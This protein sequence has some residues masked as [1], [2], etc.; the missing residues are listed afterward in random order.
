M[1]TLLYTFSLYINTS[2]LTYLLRL[3]WIFDPPSPKNPS[4]PF[5]KTPYLNS[6]P[7]LTSIQL[8]SIPK[9]NPLNQSCSNQSIPSISNKCIASNEKTLSIIWSKKNKNKPHPYFPHHPLNPLHK[10][11]KAKIPYQKSRKSLKK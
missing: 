6:L 5:S 3:Q 9:N 10:T 1:F 8:N 7:T 11:L 2:T 4:I